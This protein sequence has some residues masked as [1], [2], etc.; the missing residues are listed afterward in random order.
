[1]GGSKTLARFH[2]RLGW[3]GV[4]VFMIGGLLLE[5]LH[6][7]KVGFYLDV[8]NET[9][10]TMWTLAHAHGTLL[11]LLHLAW[12][13]YLAIMVPEAGGRLKL[14]SRLSV[15]GWFC[16]PL[17]FFLGGLAIYDGDPGL[18]IAFAPVGALAWIAAIVLLM[19]VSGDASSAAP[20]LGEQQSR[21][22][23]RGGNRK[24]RP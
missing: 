7:F 5:V 19:S 12:G 1:M 6:G 15:L 3:M 2:F 8:G 11:S 13:A 4:G 23:G 22:L 20:P 16:L 14:A 21:H 18:G 24:R 17:G 10:R 9:R